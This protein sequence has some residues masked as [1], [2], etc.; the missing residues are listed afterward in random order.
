MLTDSGFFQGA[1]CPKEGCG[2]KVALAPLAAEWHC[3]NGGVLNPIQT[4]VR[5][6]SG[7]LQTNIPVTSDLES[8]MQFSIYH[9]V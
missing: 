9:Y 6:A 2:L 8:K 3:G 7:R 4:L 5:A 1:L